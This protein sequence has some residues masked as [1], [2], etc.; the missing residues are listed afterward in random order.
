MMSPTHVIGGYA[1]TGTFAALAGENIFATKTNIACVLI[2][3]LLPDIDLPKSPISWLILPVSRWINRNWGHRTYT[4][5]IWA[6]MIVIAFAWLMRDVFHFGLSPLIC[7]IAFFSHLLLDMITKMGVML[8]YPFSEVV[9]VIPSNPNLRFTTGEPKTEILVSSAFLAISIFL[10]PLTQN[11]F[12]TTVN[13]GFGVPRTLYSEFLKSQDL[14]SV[15]YE[16]QEGSNK[17]TGTGYLIACEREDCFQL[18]KND[19]F[20]KIDAQNQVVKSVVPTHTHKRFTFH[21]ITFLGINADS[22]N[23]IL[24]GKII[25]QLKIEAN[26]GFEIWQNGLLDIKASTE[27]KYPTKLYFKAIDSLP[28]KDNLFSEINF[29]A[30]RIENELQ[31]IEDEY[32]FKMAEYNRHRDSLL[33]YDNLAKNEVNYTN[34]EFYIRRKNSINVPDYPQK[35]WVN[36]KA[37]QAALRLSNEKFDFEQRKKRFELESQ[38]NKELGRIQKTSFVGVLKYVVIE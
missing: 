16:I 25:C 33:L 27:I 10:Y 36:V 17:K 9:G 6:L 22:V 15:D 34:K 30:K 24:K 26:K 29:E 35:D 2:C 19:T 23:A 31:R 5:T 13:R 7:G 14:L 12:W 11:G 1:I 3:S 38:F 4:H 28:S 20:V 21:D 8:L 18:W 32:R 37:L